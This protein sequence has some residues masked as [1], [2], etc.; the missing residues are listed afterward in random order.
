MNLP[1]KS[2]NSH[3]LNCGSEVESDAAFCYHCGQKIRKIPLPVRDFLGDFVQDYFTVD[4][5]FFRSIRLLIL[6]PGLMT[7]RF[8]HGKRLSFIAPF[9]F[10]I[11]VSFVYF[12][13]L[14]LSTRDS[15]MDFIRGS[16]TDHKAQLATIDS[17]LADTALVAKEGDVLRQIREMR[18]AKDSIEQDDD[19]AIRFDTDADKSGSTFFEEIYETRKERIE[20][21][22]ELFKQALF[23]SS[24]I[25]V[26]FLLPVFALLLMLL[27]FRRSKF[28]VDHLVLSIHFH[29]FIFVI[30]CLFILLGMWS[31]EVKHW[32]MMTL[33]LG[34]FVLLGRHIWTY[35]PA[36]VF[37]KVMAAVLVVL[38]ATTLVPTFFSSPGTSDAFILFAL[39]VS[40]LTLALMNAYSQ[41]FLKS[42]LKTML[43][44]P[45][46]ALV[47]LFVMIGVFM[48]GI[49][50]A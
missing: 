21:N 36:T 43:I 37:K 15:N 44:V 42:S 35:P 34:Y 12:F 32:V 16:Q 40:Y 39:S 19:F 29:T 2:T 13:L 46:Y 17:L 11:F 22:P 27:H 1:V 9:R 5:K 33:A 4:Q 38:V 10:Y 14:A 20:Q 48:I 50:L 23:K 6:N 45:L 25:G 41:G 31:D 7:R 30:F 28:Y 26:F 18:L 47:I 3:C 49:F 24:S 8:N